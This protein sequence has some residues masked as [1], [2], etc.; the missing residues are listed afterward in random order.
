MRPELRAAVVYAL[1]EAGGKNLGAALDAQWSSRKDLQPE[2]L[3]MTG[4]AMLQVQDA[5]AAQVASLLASEAVRQGDLV[6]WKGS[7]VPLLDADYNNDAE[8]TAYAVRLLARIDPNNP[9]LGGAAQWLMLARNGGEWWDSTEQTAMVL[10][11]LVDYL[12]ASHELE[13]DFT[14]DVLINGHSAGQ[15]HFTAADAQSGNSFAIDIDA[16][17]LQAG[18]N[19]MQVVRRSGSGRVYWSARGQY[20]STEKKDFQAGTMSLNLTRDYSKLQP[21]QKNGKIVYTLQP[22]SGTA[23]VGDVLAVHEAINGTPM[24]YLMLEDPIPAGTEFVQSEDSYP[25]DQRPGGWYDWFT[26]REYHDDHAAFFA[27]DF[28]GRQEIFYMIRVVNPGTFQISPA[29]VEPMY[30]PGVQATSDA[31]QLQVPAPAPPGSSQPGGAQ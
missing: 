16:A 2:A 25:L 5:R 13:S 31:L 10:F 22:L 4:L 29:R 8:A 7:Y 20:Y 17:H 27:D 14:A 30:Q 24:R 19:S 28:T 1:A 9:L 6:S 21:T 23:Q 11:G 15:R 26:R 3:A 18:S 12:A